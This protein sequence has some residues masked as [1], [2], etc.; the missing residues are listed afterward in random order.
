MYHKGVDVIVQAHTETYHTKTQS[1]SVPVDVY[2]HTDAGTQW[3]I[4]CDILCLFSDRA[5]QKNTHY[6][7][8]T[9]CIF[10]HLS[11]DTSSLL[12]KQATA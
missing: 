9:Q 2:A 12:L 3:E 10:T 5:G 11:A 7:F 1:N 4:I 6:F 8:N